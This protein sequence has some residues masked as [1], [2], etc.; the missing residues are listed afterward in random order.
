MKLREKHL[1]LY[2]GYIRFEINWSMSDWALP[3]AIS[4]SKHLVFIQF[5][6]VYFIFRRNSKIWKIQN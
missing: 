5:L 6:C 1:S 3:F 4:V 2:S